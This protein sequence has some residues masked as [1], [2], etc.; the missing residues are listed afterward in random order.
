M[1]L[2]FS[3]DQAQS[4]D[5]MT[6]KSSSYQMSISIATAAKSEANGVV[7]SAFLLI[8]LTFC[9]LFAQFAL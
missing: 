4:S 7:E 1:E 6:N 3:V 9:C 8:Y 5:L 2:S